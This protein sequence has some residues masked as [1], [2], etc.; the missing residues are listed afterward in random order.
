MNGVVIR[1]KRVLILGGSY[2]IGK[3]ILETVL[4]AGYE[5]YA[6]NRGT[7][8]LYNLQVNSIVC[9]RNNAENMQKSL[10][11]YSFDIVI[12]VS[13]LNLQQ[14]KILCDSIGR[15]KIKK[16]FFISSS[17]VY[18]LDNRVAPFK[19][20]DKLSGNKYWEE[21]GVD[22]IQAEQYYIGQFSNTITEL[23]ILRPP[24]VYGENNYVQ[25]ESFIFD[26]IC[27]DKP[28]IIP[29]PDIKLQF[30]YIKDLANIIL[31]LM[32]C[33]LENVSIF[34]VGNKKVI[35]T[36]EWVEICSKVAGKKANIMEFD[37]EKY[38]YSVKGFFPFH[39]YDNVLD[40]SRINGMYP[41][42][43]PM[44]VGLG[45]AF[46]W[47]LENKDIIKFKEQVSKNE[48]MILKDHLD[49]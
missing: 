21:Y 27:K 36:Q 35:T 5:V 44:E 37:Y 32:E 48:Y 11:G 42:E 39:S 9:D 45:K 24:Y 4:E 33:K 34:N 26:H 40:V 41:Q 13:G 25:R 46:D 22:K 19:E 3:S 47:Y 20:D 2:F 30:I 12:D 7:T 29:K 23:I 10:K 38:G 8:G 18:D 6:L 15:D 14:S 49:N 16:F 1:M 31:K 28:V 43:T 17:S